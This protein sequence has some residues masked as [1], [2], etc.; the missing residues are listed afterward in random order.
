MAQ[1]VA[2]NGMT[3]S[4][5]YMHQQPSTAAC[6]VLFALPAGEDEVIIVLK[7]EYKK[8]WNFLVSNESNTKENWFIINDSDE[9]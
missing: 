1:V 6:Y 5:P 8:I 2:P 9:L 4:K 7:L 3:A